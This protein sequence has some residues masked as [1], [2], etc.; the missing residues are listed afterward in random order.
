MNVFE[1]R[2]EDYH[3]PDDWRE[4]ILSVVFDHGDVAE[5]AGKDYHDE[6]DANDLSLIVF[7]REKGRDTEIKKF[8]VTADYSINYYSEE[9][10]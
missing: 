2:I 4:M 6:G 9:I 1:Y 10:E 3:G 7:V 8:C 5:M